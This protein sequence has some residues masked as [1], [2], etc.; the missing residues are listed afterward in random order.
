MK[1]T[2]LIPVLAVLAG[3]AGRTP[4]PVDV[5]QVHDNELSCEQIRSEILF[6]AEK[7]TG[8]EQEQTRK[9]VQNVSAGLAGVVF[10][11]L[12]FAMDFQDA[13]GKEEQALAARNKYLAR[14]YARR[15]S[16]MRPTG[17]YAYRQ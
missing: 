11:P 6:N 14:A 9:I 12:L 16:V 13:A 10:F 5:V 7:I 3:C 4:E 8:L 17:G 15:C 2:F 1:K